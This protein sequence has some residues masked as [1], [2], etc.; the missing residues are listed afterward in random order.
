MKSANSMN[1]TNTLL[2]PCFECRILMSLS[3]RV[4]LDVDLTSLV[5]VQ[6]KQPFEQAKHNPNLKCSGS[7]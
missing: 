2:E 6:T 1:A 3:L 7:L 4:T 5:G